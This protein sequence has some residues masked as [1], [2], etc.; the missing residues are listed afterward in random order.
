MRILIAVYVA[1]ALCCGLAAASGCKIVASVPFASQLETPIK[2]YNRAGPRLATAG[3]LTPADIIEVRNQGFDVVVNATPSEPDVI[4]EER[5]LVEAQG[6]AYRHLPYT[7]EGVSEADLAA[8][9]TL[10]AD[11]TIRVLIHCKAGSRA[12]ALLTAHQLSNGV[13]REAALTAGRAAGLQPDME[14]ELIERLTDS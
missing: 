3:T 4:A 13:E 9:N 8:L 6:M 5:R 2:H 7:D 14:A 1:W 12:G 11:D 10:L